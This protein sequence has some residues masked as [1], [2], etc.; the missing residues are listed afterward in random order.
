MMGAI[1]QFL[2]FLLDVCFWII[3]IQVVLSWLIL[4]DVINVRNPQAANFV[5][6]IE[7]ITDPVYKPLRKV[8]PP[9]AGIDITPIIL[10]FAIYLLK[11]LVA[12]VFFA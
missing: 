1:G 8:I 6:L 2:L 12:S 5:R 7:R 3:I 11:S 4:F 10:I 9:I